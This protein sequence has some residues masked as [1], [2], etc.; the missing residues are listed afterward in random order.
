MADETFIKKCI[1]CGREKTVT[2]A[3][4]YF[5]KKGIGLNCRSCS[6]KGNKRRLLGDSYDEN[7]YGTHLYRVWSNMKNR[8]NNCKSNDY[9]RYGGRGIKVCEEWNSFRNFFNDMGDSCKEELTLD[10]INNNGN[11]CKENCR[12]ATAKEQAL[13]T[14]N[15][16]RAKKYKFNGISKTIKEWAEQFGIKRTTLDMRLR[17]YKWS[18][19][20]SLILGG[21][22]Y[23]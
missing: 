9:K 22:S 17:Q 14:R 18:M 23:H 12:W 16:D 10:R 11:Y 7:L 3:M 19:E 8:C 15:I 20:K 2:R 5:M 6:S 21:G 13:N 1:K 4:E